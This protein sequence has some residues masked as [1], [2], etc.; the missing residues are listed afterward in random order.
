[1][2]VSDVKYIAEAGEICFSRTEIIVPEKYEIVGVGVGV[3][4][5]V[6]C[7]MG[8]GNKNFPGQEDEGR[9]DQ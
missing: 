5:L 8:N 1:V 3:T 2:T 4:Y 9:M 7:E 6:L